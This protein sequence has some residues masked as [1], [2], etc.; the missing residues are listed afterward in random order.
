MLLKK[1]HIKFQSGSIIIGLLFIFL[2]N[3]SYS[4]D[5]K[6][7]EKSALI[8]GS[9]FHISVVSED[10][11]HT[12][13]AIDEAFEEM[14]RIEFLISEWIPETQISQVNQQAGIRPVKVD[15]EVFKLTQR[16]LQYSKLS[17]G[18]FDIS[19]A[20]MDRIWD[21]SGF[22]DSLPSP[23]EIK[24]SVRNV[25]YQK[26]LLNPQDTTIFLKDIGMKI[27]F[28]SIGK[29]Y[30][31]DKAK[32]VLQAKGI[33]SGIVNASGDMAIWGKPI[34]EKKWKIGIKNPFKRHGVAKVLRLNHSSIA[35][36]GSYEKFVE[37]NN[38]RYGHII[39][40]KTGMPSTGLTSV[41]VY[42]PS[43]E[44]A[45]ALSTSIMVMGKKKGKKLLKKF[46]QYRGVF[47][48]DSGKII[49]I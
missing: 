11:I 20:A 19:I 3:F 46:P 39:N 1:S 7:I 49:K 30:A 25:D 14:K 12:N 36:S 6:L 27:G 13:I 23:I 29:S 48:T 21:F 28:G 18:A 10:S 38:T 35:T 17:N 43:T 34:N 40:P 4:Q 44:F 24:Q 33:E 41:T 31:A 42:G 22:M 15:F 45:N 16:A 9:T 26:I 5:K 32:E 2:A 8:M 37:I 47:I